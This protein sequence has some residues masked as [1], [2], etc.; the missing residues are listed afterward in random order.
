[1]TLVL[2]IAIALML[3]TVA[4][5]AGNRDDEIKRAVARLQPPK[6]ELH[7]HPYMGG[8]ERFWAVVKYGRAALPFLI[9][10]LT[11][12]ARMRQP[13]PYCGGDYARADA[14]D[15]AIEEIV[16]IPTWDFLEE[17]FSSRT[18]EIGYCAKL[19]YLRSSKINRQKY[20]A[21][22]REWLA[23]NESRLVWIPTGDDSPTGGYWGLPNAPK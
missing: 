13:M 2:R 17:P 22:V 12:T 18:K 21:K 9:D 4:V 1:M 16:R 14:A 5:S 11:N 6:E 20:Q 3:I 15:D 7:N 19:Q 10:E 8:D 23:A